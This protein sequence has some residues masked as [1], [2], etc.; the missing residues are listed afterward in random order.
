MTAWLKYQIMD[1]VK[2]PECKLLEGRD[3]VVLTVW[4]SMEPG[5]L[6]GL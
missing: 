6:N 4:I 2:F 5:L 3:Y 1:M